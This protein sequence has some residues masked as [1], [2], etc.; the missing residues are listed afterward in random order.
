MKLWPVNDT[1]ANTHA[2]LA[3][4]STLWPL[5]C[6]FLHK[7]QFIEFLKIIFRKVCYGKGLRA[8]RKFLPKPYFV[9]TEGALEKFLMI[10]NSH[11]EVLP[12]VGTVPFP[13]VW[14]KYELFH[15]S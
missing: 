12:L 2:V 5:N 7:Q 15:S 9:Q 10:I 8:L 14:L 4:Y 1:L 3:G 6:I 11:D 13:V